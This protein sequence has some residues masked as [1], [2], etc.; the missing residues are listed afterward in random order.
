MEILDLKMKYSVENSLGGFN[1]R[2][3]MEGKNL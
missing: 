3:E 2:L 1:S